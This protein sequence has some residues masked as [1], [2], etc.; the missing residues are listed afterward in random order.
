MV[1]PQLREKEFENPTKHISIIV[2]G[3]SNYLN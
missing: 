2:W 3:L 1:F